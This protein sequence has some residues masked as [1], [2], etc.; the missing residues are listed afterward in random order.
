MLV[1]GADED[2][3]NAFFDATLLALTPTLPMLFLWY[4]R[5][6]LVAR[7]LHPEFLL[8]ESETFELNRAALLHDKIS[9]RLEE[10]ADRERPVTRFWAMPTSRHRDV[11]EGRRFERQNLEA[12]ARHLRGVMSDLRRRPLLR[13]KDWIGIKSAQFALANA[14]A[15]HVMSLALLLL[16]AF[17][18]A[19]RTAVS[20]H[21]VSTIVST[22][23][24]FDENLLYA[25]AVATAFAAMAAPLFYFV[26]WLSL[27]RQHN[28]EFSIFSDLAEGDHYPVEAANIDE[29]TLQ[30][31]TVV[32]HAEKCDWFTVL[33]LS[34]SA[35][36]EEVKAA[37]RALIKQNHPDRVHGMSPIYRQLAERR[38]Q[39]INAAYRQALVTAAGS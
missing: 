28:L 21:F 9:R 14:I 3:W 39:E 38:T 32:K 27:R 26:R 33:G 15:I 29:E 12:H 31:D 11:P 35:T 4:A 37:Y 5:Q 10:I 20:Q 2:F 22:R 19:E 30:P 7:Q 1:S 13:L 18:I 36:I 16:L 17:P 23:L 8:H 25:N 34:Q 6:W 24:A